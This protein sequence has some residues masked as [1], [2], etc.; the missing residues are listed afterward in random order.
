MMERL[1]GPKRRFFI[2]AL[3]IGILAGIVLTEWQARQEG[4]DARLLAAIQRDDTQ[5][6]ME[7]LKEGA[8]ANAA[9]RVGRASSP[10][11]VFHDLRMWLRGR[12]PPPRSYFAS[13][14]Y[15]V[16]THEGDLRPSR[17][18]GGQ[19]ESA[20]PR[21]TLRASARAFDRVVPRPE[22]AEL[23]S[24]LLRHGADPNSYPGPAGPLHFAVRMQ[25]D[26]VV[27]LLLEHGANP[28]AG[29]EAIS[30]PLTYA[31]AASTELLIQH[32]AKVNLRGPLG[33]TALM[34]AAMDSGQE[35]P[36]RLGL[37]LRHGADAGMRDAYGQT[38]LMHAA[39]VGNARVLLDRGAEVDARD[40][41]GATA[42]MMA[43]AG[44]RGSGLPRLLI[45]YGARA[46]AVDH[47]GR[48][49]RDY[50]M[51]YARGNNRTTLCRFLNSVEAAERQPFA[52]H[53]ARH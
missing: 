26:A 34:A 41:N 15:L 8:N 6:A 14:L 12:R 18:S 25:H 35:G 2:G 39:D 40:R 17:G 31:D 30:L 4:L 53:R 43:C 28:N 3:V 19:S 10:D 45:Q 51:G 22:R 50:A 27:R 9:F 24:V 42:L 47:A 21:R 33:Q 5:A 7:A 23:V 49:A 44:S 11:L 1:P 48:R 29:N 16:Y 46:T 36:A 32:G 52:A 38:A 20:S 13:A 37:L